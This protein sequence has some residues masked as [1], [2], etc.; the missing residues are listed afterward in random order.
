MSQGCPGGD[1][2]LCCH[3]ILQP[4]SCCPPAPISAISETQRELGTEP[5]SHRAAARGSQAPPAWTPCL[6]HG[7]CTGRVQLVPAP[8]GRGQ[9]G[10][11][12]H[13]TALGPWGSS[14]GRPDVGTGSLLPLPPSQQVTHHRRQRRVREARSGR[15]TLGLGCWEE[16]GKCPSTLVPGAS[17]PFPW[18]DI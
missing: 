16:R 15:I 4:P 18:G 14:W 6:R 8:N 17:S 2:S 3:R 7:G 1:P 10:C 13:P 11:S 5:A 12:P 9:Q